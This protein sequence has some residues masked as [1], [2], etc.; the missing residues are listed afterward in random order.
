MYSPKDLS[1]S[2]GTG[3]RLTA[4][5]LDEATDAVSK[6]ALCTEARPPKTM[7][8]P[9]ILPLSR[10]KGATPTSA[11][12]SLRLSLPSSGRSAMSVCETTGATPGTPRRAPPSH[13]TRDSPGSPG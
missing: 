13:A 6:S 5:R 3:D 11:A 1:W 4:A 10:A 12:I 9:C 2:R 7:R 8:L